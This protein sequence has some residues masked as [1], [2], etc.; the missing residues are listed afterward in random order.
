LQLLSLKSYEAAMLSCS[1]GKL[2]LH[3]PVAHS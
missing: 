3:S 1:S 2:K